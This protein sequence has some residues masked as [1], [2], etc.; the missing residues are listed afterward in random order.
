MDNADLLK[1]LLF[2]G[3]FFICVFIHLHVVISI[4]FKDF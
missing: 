4:V 2:Y 1:N 3:S